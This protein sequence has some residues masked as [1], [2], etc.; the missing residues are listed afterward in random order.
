MLSFLVV[1]SK[2]NFLVN[3]A[4]LAVASMY[5][6]CGFAWL[7]KNNTIF[8]K[9]ELLRLGQHGD[10]LYVVTWGFHAQ[11]TELIITIVLVLT[12]EAKLKTRIWAPN[13]LKPL[14]LPINLLHWNIWASAKNQGPIMALLP[15]NT[16]QITDQN[17]LKGCSNATFLANLFSVL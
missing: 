8:E 5:Y 3:M 10:L 17:K 6:S 15:A 14:L 2:C 7:V 1:D 16:S 4:T 13:S 9:E 11:T 12:V